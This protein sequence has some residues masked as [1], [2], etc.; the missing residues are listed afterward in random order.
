MK[1]KG[2][3]ERSNSCRRNKSDP[4]SDQIKPSRNV[5]SHP[6]QLTPVPQDGT[7]HAVIKEKAMLLWKSVWTTSI[8]G[9]TECD[10]DEWFLKGG[11]C[12]D[13]SPS[14][15]PQLFL[16]FPS[17]FLFALWW[18]ENCVKDQQLAWRLCKGCWHPRVFLNQRKNCW[19]PLK[20]YCGSTDA[21]K[22][23]CFNNWTSFS[24]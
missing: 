9:A 11:F 1:A 2:L 18:W 14:L 13:V 4:I 10:S 19:R 7:A 6:F 23:F 3:S 5:W 12:Q 21:S 8:L 24:H 20:A 15:S 22:R 17:L 16:L